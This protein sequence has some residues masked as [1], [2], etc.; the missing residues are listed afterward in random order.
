LRPK[1]RE[2]L[3]RK[4]EQVFADYGIVIQTEIS[5]VTQIRTGLRQCCLLFKNETRT[6]NKTELIKVIVPL[7]QAATNQA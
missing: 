2:Q 5:I 3:R 4:S 7:S 6:L 1:T